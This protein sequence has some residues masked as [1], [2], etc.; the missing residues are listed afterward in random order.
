V[1]FASASSPPLDEQVHI[2]QPSKQEPK[3]FDLPGQKLLVLFEEYGK[4]RQELRYTAVLVPEL[5]SQRIRVRIKRDSYDFQSYALAEVYDTTRNEWNE[6]VRIHYNNMSPSSAYSDE[7][8]FK[9]AVTVDASIL[10]D[11]ALKVLGL[12]TNEEGR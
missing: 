8:K 12:R 10:L 11:R 2:R 9:N 6:I 5:A 4:G 3:A 1:H 7:A